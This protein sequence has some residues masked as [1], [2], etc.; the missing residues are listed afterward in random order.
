MMIKYLTGDAT[1]PTG[2]GHKL[3]V[4][5]CNDLGK[6]GRGF[7]TAVSKRWKQPEAFYRDSFKIKPPQLG[8]VQFVSIDPL[9]TVANIIGQHGIR[10][11]R[12]T[13]APPPI[14]Y[15]AVREGLEKVA[16]FSLKY[17][18]SVHMPRI[19]CGLAGGSW[20]DVEPIIMSTLIEKGVSVSVYDLC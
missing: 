17:N 5:V 8:E 2:D 13:K 6:W 11:P 7:V 4:H 18:A 16:A 12:N 15:E 9:T 19:G 14:R 10:S 3:I 1:R 20:E